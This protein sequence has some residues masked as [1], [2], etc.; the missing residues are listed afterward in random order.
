MTWA[1]NPIHYPFSAPEDGGGVGQLVEKQRASTDAA[2]E[3][4]KYLPR[5]RR[6]RLVLDA[7][8]NHAYKT[9]GACS[10]LREPS[11]NS[12]ATKPRAS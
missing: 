6:Q 4:L 5:G 12:E 8:D 7:F 11:L 9:S 3:R 2:A 10:S 1:Q